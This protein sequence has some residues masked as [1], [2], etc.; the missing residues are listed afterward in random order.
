MRE[1]GLDYLRNHIDELLYLLR[2]GGVREVLYAIE[3]NGEIG[4]NS[5]TNLEVYF[6][7]GKDS[8]VFNPSFNA[9]VMEDISRQL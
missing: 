7:G 9:K 1:V 3:L 6:R 2:M 4:E 5:F 8:F